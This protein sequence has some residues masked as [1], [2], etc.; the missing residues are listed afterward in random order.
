M[1]TSHAFPVQ[2]LT[3]QL[4]S[5]MPLPG[6]SSGKPAARTMPA[7]CGDAAAELPASS[8]AELLHSPSTPWRMNE[9]LTPCLASQ[10]MHL[11]NHSNSCLQPVLPGGGCWDLQPKGCANVWQLSTLRFW[12]P[13][14]GS[15]STSLS[16]R[17]RSSWQPNPALGRSEPGGYNRVRHG[18]LGSPQDENKGIPSH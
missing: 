3:F 11:H 13:F 16:Q 15:R 14:S 10:G 12:E 7:C 9:L 17:E 1:P 8:G 6:A 5:A 2:L 18:V 4:P